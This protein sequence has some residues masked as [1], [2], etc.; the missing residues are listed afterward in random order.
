MIIDL[1]A[2]NGDV[3]FAALTDVE[4]IFLRASLG[5]GTVDKML[6]MRAKEA[7]DNNIP[8][9]Y[10]HFSYPHDKGEDV[11]ADAARQAN[12][13]V[14]VISGLPA[15]KHLAVDLENL[16]AKTD[17][18]LSKGD[19]AIWLQNFLD[20][21]EALIGIR[22]IIYTY[23]DYLNRHL[24]DGHK[25]GAYDLWIANYGKV[26]QPPLPKGWTKALAWQYSDVGN[27]PGVKGRVDLSKFV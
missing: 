15:P 11:A 19:Y 13:F 3:N 8:V 26:N 2:N 24:P 9:S 21:V 23:A 25:F 5:F 6:D 20:T 18:T 7:A 17:T 12:Y 1:S 16:S 10:Y 22:C 27:I 14:H 4:E